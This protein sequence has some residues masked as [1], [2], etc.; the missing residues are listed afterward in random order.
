MPVM[1]ARDDGNPEYYTRITENDIKVGDKIVV[2]ELPE[3]QTFEGRRFKQA[4]VRFAVADGIIPP[5][6]EK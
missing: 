2:Y 5:L 1:I 4:P 3:G 6:P